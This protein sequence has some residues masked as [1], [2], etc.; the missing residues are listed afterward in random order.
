MAMTASP[1]ANDTWW[2]WKIAENIQLLDHLANNW[3]TGQP[4]LCDIKG[5]FPIDGGPAPD[6]DEEHGAD[7]LGNQRS[8]EI[9]PTFR[10]QRVCRDHLES[11]EHIFRKG[12]SMGRE[13][14]GSKDQTFPRVLALNILEK[15]RIISLK[16][17]E[18]F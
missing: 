8:G 2:T 17:T 3:S 6:D 5:S 12:Y 1:K 4:N 10:Q 13:V 7:E 11:E 14:R 9:P 18:V 16:K 15:S